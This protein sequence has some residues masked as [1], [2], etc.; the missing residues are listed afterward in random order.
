MILFLL[1][2]RLPSSDSSCSRRGVGSSLS[3]VEAGN[4]LVG[5]K[6]SPSSPPSRR[7]SKSSS[8]LLNGTVISHPIPVAAANGSVPVDGTP[9]ATNGIGFFG[10]HEG[11]TI[12]PINTNN[13][14]IANGVASNTNDKTIMLNNA[15]DKK[16]SSVPP[17]PVRQAPLAPPTSGKMT[18]SKPSL[19]GTTNRSV[20]PGTHSSSVPPSMPKSI[21]PPPPPSMPPV[22]VVSPYYR[23]TQLSPT[24]NSTQGKAP[25]PLSVP[26][27]NS[28]NVGHGAIANNSNHSSNNNSP[29]HI[30]KPSTVSRLASFLSKKD[31]SGEVS[32]EEDSS[33]SSTLPR[34]ASK[35]NRES[36]MQLEISAP[37]QLQA[38]KLPENLVPVRP[39]PCPPSEPNLKPSEVKI[40]QSYDDKCKGKAVNIPLSEESNKSSSKVTWAPSVDK[41]VKVSTSTS[42]DVH[43]IGSMR[44]QS[45][46]MRPAITK[47]GSMRAPR[48]KSLPPARPSDPPPRPPLPTIPSPA[49]SEDFYDDCIEDPDDV[50]YPGY[51]PEGPVSPA[52]SIYATID[53]DI[54]P[55]KLTTQL[56]EEVPLK[57]D[58]QEPFYANS[59]AIDLPDKQPKKSV[60]SFLYAKTKRKKKDSVEEPLYC[61]IAERMPSAPD[62]VRSHSPSPPHDRT[63]CG[64]S[65]DG[66]L[67][68]EI[69]SELV[70]REP[71]FKTALSKNKNTKILAKSNNDKEDAAFRHRITKIDPPVD[72]KPVSNVQSTSGKVPK[73]ISYPWKSN[74]NTDSPSISNSLSSGSDSKT[75]ISSMKPRGVFSYLKRNISDDENTTICR[76]ISVEPI[77]AIADIKNPITAV[78]NTT[79]TTH[80]NVGTTVP[81]ARELTLQTSKSLES[82][83]AS[84]RAASLQLNSNIPSS[85]SLTTSKSTTPLYTNVPNKIKPIITQNI[86]KPLNT[87]KQ[88]PPALPTKKLSLENKR[89]DI[90]KITKTENS[91]EKKVISDELDTN[92]SSNISGN[93]SLTKPLS[94]ASEKLKSL[95]EVNNGT[96]NKVHARP[97]FPPDKV[98]M[99]TNKVEKKDSVVSNLTKGINKS[100][101]AAKKTPLSKVKSGTPSSSLSLASKTSE[102]SVKQSIASKPRRVLSPPRTTSSKPLS[103]SD[104]DKSKSA[105]S[106]AAKSERNSSNRSKSPTSPSSSNGDLSSKDNVR[107]T[108]NAVGGIRSSGR[109]TSASSGSVGKG[110]TTAFAGKSVGSSNVA[111]LQ[112]KFEKEASSENIKVENSKQVRASARRTSDTRPT[113][114]PKPWQ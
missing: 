61:N 93:A 103:T 79:I 86:N 69:V 47:F 102:S 92:L 80:I 83:L 15:N 26:D 27:H 59:D 37:M 48:P 82:S 9:A 18:I 19:K 30:G 55:T 23:S 45:V 108:S 22:A 21:P 67:L 97:F 77:E 64:S 98:S 25:R 29:A 3:A 72:A 35:I 12:S 46:T 38:T 114:A 73:S 100:T 43:R 36:L 5:V 24:Q 84:V 42:G 52:E 90:P 62:A 14:N 94:S 65:E 16:A 17:Q 54:I 58:E 101:G 32:D 8:P 20:L 60:F 76:D 74:S 56:S 87:N 57:Q 91:S 33:R 89:N 51:Q 31:K 11:F 111:S 71:T 96:V 75:P 2:N 63:S 13:K 49:E 105:T 28:V 44:E 50:G 110:G 88:I 53:E 85:T 41:Q 70:T 107:K 78:S 109:R 104:G 7:G 1:S 34:K 81:E 95:S 4:G 99:P 112:Q 39:A 113:A 68:S 40:S 6:R 106:Q 66:G 10:V